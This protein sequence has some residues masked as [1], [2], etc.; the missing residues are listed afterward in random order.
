MY[1][2]RKLIWDDTLTTGDS[3]IDAQHKFLIEKFNEMGDAIQHGSGMDSISNILGVLRN[4][5]DWHFAKEEG[6]MESYHCPVAGVNKIAHE[7]FIEKT[8]KYQKEYELSGGST[9]LALHIHT[10]LSDWIMNHI[11]VVD[12]QLYPCIHNKP[13]PKKP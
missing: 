12:G 8:N 11:L 10:E 2:P 9:K 4:Y 1:N 3:E 13:K 7:V 5:A 6:C